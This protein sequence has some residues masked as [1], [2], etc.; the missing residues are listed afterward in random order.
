MPKSALTFSIEGMDAQMPD[1]N[2]KDKARKTL[3]TS[4]SETVEFTLE[5]SGEV[6]VA[7]QPAPPKGPPDKP[8]HPRRRLPRVPDAPPKQTGEEEK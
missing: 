3:D 6:V 2:A 7:H 8:I 1:Q 4:S 5:S